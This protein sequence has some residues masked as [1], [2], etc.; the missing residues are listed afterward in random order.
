MHKSI[1]FL[2]LFL[3]S[4]LYAQTNA[5]TNKI[6]THLEALT[7]T[8]NFRNYHN[9]LTLDTVADYIYTEFERYCDTVFYQVYTVEGHAFMNVVGRINT[10][11]TEK[12]VVGAHYDV[13][14]EQQGADDNASGVAGL[15]ELA[16]M[17]EADT[18]AQYQYELVA[19]TLEEPPFFRSNLMGSAIHAK[20]LMDSNEVIVGMVCLEM[21]GYFDERKKSQDYPLGILKLFYGSRGDYITVVEQFGP[22]KFARKFGK[23]MKRAGLIKTKIFK[24]PKG[25]PGIDFSDHLNYW[26]YDI[27]AVMITDT[28]FYRNKNYHQKTDTLETLNI[29]KMALVIDE[30]Y[31]SL[32]NW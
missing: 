20:S 12:I 15:L 23:Q 3:Q 9:L 4:A 14:D 18:T 11:K 7:Q 2:T 30:V 24:G 26:A 32:L 25:L 13:C 31:L 22:G 27:S 8:E 17:L 28:A 10:D 21:I 6:T 5:D 19:Y 1:L 16:R 29:P